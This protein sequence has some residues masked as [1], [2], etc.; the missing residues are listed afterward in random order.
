MLKINVQDM[1]TVS[2]LTMMP[3]WSGILLFVHIFPLFCLHLD[4]HFGNVA[5][6]F[7]VW[8]NFMWKCVKF[9]LSTE[10]DFND[11]YVNVAIDQKCRKNC[12][13]RIS[14]LLV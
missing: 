11:E 2:F 14:S 1:N 8:C 12:C 6:C 5:K 7:T 10:E 3:G 9:F 13:C 4:A